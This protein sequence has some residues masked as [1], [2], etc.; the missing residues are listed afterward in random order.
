MLFSLALIPVFALLAVIYFNDKKEKEPIGLLAGLFFAGMGT[1][2]TAIIAELVGQIA[3][4]V[5]IPYNSALNAVVLSLFIIAPAEEL[6]KFAVLRLITWKN[7]NFN[8]SYD[9]IVYAV[10]ASLGFA[11]VENIMYVFTNGVGTALLRMFTAVPG[12]ACDAVFMGFFYS[13]AKYAQLTNKKDKQTLY[14]ALTIIVPIVLHGIYDAIIMGGRA[15]ND[16]LITGFSV[17]LWIGYVIALFAGSV[18]TVIYSAKH[19]FCIVTV[20]NAAQAVYKPA[21]M[22]SWR[23]ICGTENNF[24]FCSQ[25]GHQRPIEEPWNCPKCGTLSYYKFCGNCGCQ[26]PVSG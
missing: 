22:G 5:I 10:F 18:V 25:C 9:A 12:H 8:Y 4:N 15:T 24:N 2:I 3:L 17:L 21:V 19:D 26:R 7:K 16:G 1:V 20:P 13:K 14:T 11:A 6:G 23:C